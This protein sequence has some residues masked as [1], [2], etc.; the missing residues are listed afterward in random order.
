MFANSNQMGYN[1]YDEIRWLGKNLIC[2][3]H[4]KENDNLLGRGKVDFK[5][6]RQAIDDIGYT[7]WIQI[8]GAI[9]PF[10]QMLESY[11]ANNQYLRTA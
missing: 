1:I 4:A 6:V 3:I 11:V 7:G 8:E 9:P 2:E 10:Q 5:E